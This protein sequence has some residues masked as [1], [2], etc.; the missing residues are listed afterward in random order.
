MAIEIVDFPIQ[1]GDFPIQNGDFCY[2]SHYQRVKGDK[3]MGDESSGLGKRPHK[4]LRPK[5][6]IFR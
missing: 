5:P 6:G 3:M 2:V 4:K 1:H